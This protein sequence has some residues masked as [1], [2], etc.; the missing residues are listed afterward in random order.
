MSFKEADYWY[1]YGDGSDIS[2]YIVSMKRNSGKTEA[3][4]IVWKESGTKIQ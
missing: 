1:G 3:L 2:R 4:R